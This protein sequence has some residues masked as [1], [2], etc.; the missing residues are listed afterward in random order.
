MVLGL[1]RRGRVPSRPGEPPDKVVS[2][3]QQPSGLGWLPN[4]DLLVSSMLD[5]TLY[6]WSKRKD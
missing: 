5:K 6:R 2:V 4:G 3:P 1:L